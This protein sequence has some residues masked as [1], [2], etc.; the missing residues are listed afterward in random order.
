M[1]LELQRV[2]GTLQTIRGGAPTGTSSPVP[3]ESPVAPRPRPAIRAA[4]RPLDY[5]LAPVQIKL[6][7]S[8]TAGQ[9][10]RVTYTAPPYHYIQNLLYPGDVGGIEG[11]VAEYVT[12]SGCFLLENQSQLVLTPAPPADPNVRGN[13]LA[14]VVLTVDAQHGAPLGQFYFGSILLKVTL[15]QTT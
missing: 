2:A 1:A 4:P 6:P 8:G 5:N 14:G 10:V 9:P 15:I 12:F 7:V 3:R 13:L 11:F